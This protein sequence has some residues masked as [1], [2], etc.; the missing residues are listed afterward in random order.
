MPSRRLVL[1]IC[2]SI[3]VA[4]VAFAQSHPFSHSMQNN[5]APAP[6]NQLGVADV[7]SKRG[8]RGSDR[9]AKSTE[10]RATG[11]VQAVLPLL[12]GVGMAESD[13]LIF[14]PEVNYSSG[15]PYPYASSVAVGDVNGDGHPDLM[16]L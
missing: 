8:A 6:L 5:A 14:L 1:G 11:R 12:N 9:F 4:I 10:G 3:V 13:P 15:S 16:V 7:N 2:S